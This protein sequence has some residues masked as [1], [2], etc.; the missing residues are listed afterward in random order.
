[1]ATSFEDLCNQSLRKAHIPKRIGS[2]YEGSEVAN[3]CLELFGQV[4]D[5]LIRLNRPQFSRRANVAL[6][7]IKGPPPIG[8]YGP[9]A[10]W[11]PAYPPP[12]WNYEYAYP[13][14]C[15]DVGAL[16]PL[17]TLYP[18]LDPKPALWRVDDDTFDANGAPI[19][20]YKVIMAKLPGAL[21]VYWARVTNPALWDSGFTES[22]IDALAERLTENLQQKQMAQQTAVAVGAA[23]ER[24]QG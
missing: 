10:P 22:F 2:A 23:A 12:P 9:W 17:P 1:M 24:R 18:I 3:A 8:G 7:V 20:A 19:A 5:A 16:V 21:A 6:T 15:L 11:T 13:S 14:D 4:R